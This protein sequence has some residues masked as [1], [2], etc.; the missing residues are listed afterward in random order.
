M[1]G[2]I[3]ERIEIGAANLPRIQQ[4]AGAGEHVAGEEFGISAFEDVAVFIAD[5]AAGGEEIRI[6]CGRAGGRAEACEAAETAEKA[7]A[8]IE[9]RRGDMHAGKRAAMGEFDGNEVFVRGGLGD[10]QRRVAFEFEL[11]VLAECPAADLGAC[12]DFDRDELVAE[13]QNVIPGL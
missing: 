10:V 3:A 7:A 4:Q 12:S 9:S 6:P 11:A 2:L 5:L 8:R 1:T 13:V